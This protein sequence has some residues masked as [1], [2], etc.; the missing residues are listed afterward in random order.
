MRSEPWR[1]SVGF[2]F[3]TPV[4]MLMMKG[5]GWEINHLESYIWDGMRRTDEHCLFQYTVSGR[6]EITIQGITYPL[7]RGD[8]FM[9]DIPGEHC[10]RLPPSSPAWEVLYVELSKEALPFLRQAMALSGPVFELAASSAVVKRTWELYEKAIHNEIQDAYENSAFTYEWL[11][12][13]TRH[14]SKNRTQ[15]LSIAIEQCKQFIEQHYMEPIGLKEMA[16]VAGQSRF[17]FSREYERRLGI[18]PVR[19]L[20]EV[21]VAQAVKLLLSTELNQEEI[22]QRTGFSNA[23]YFGKV[24]RKHMGMSPGLFRENN[25]NYAIQHVYY[26]S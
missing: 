5:I 11:M 15:T 8:V 18:T 26:R 10:Y 20:T 2:Q 4:P 25:N 16:E 13:L 9:V 1:T 12:E 6:G 7:K 3:V 24:F 22:A 17:H 23:N 14:V 19:Y 21:R